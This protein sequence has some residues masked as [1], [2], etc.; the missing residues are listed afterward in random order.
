MVVG[1]IKMFVGQEVPVGFM[2]DREIGPAFV[3]LP[4]VEPGIV[5]GEKEAKDRDEEVERGEGPLAF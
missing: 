2:L 4:E 1:D 5:Q 3:K